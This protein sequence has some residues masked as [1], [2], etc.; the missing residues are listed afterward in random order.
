MTKTGTFWLTLTIVSLCIFGLSEKAL[1]G[2]VT[3]ATTTEQ[4]AFV[5]ATTDTVA[6]NTG[7]TVTQ[8]T[9]GTLDNLDNTSTHNSPEPATL[10][11]LGLG[12]LG[13]WWQMRR[14]RKAA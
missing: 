14:R 3:D 7:D 4:P 13:A 2:D 5:N 6:N 9:D 8:L 10:T 11:L 1:A 12:G